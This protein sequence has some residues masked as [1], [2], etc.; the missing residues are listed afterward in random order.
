MENT[1]PIDF[2]TYVDNFY[3]SRNENIVYTDAKELSLTDITLYHVKEITFE[4]KS[5]RKEALENV[6]GSLRI[7]GINFIYLIVGTKTNV[8]FYFGVVRDFSASAPPIV[9]YDIGEYVLLPSLKGNFRGSTIDYVQNDEKRKILD[10]I[11]NMENISYLEGVPGINKDN[12]NFQGSDRLVDVMLGDE[13]ALVVIAKPLLNDDVQQIE[14]NLNEAYSKMVPFVKETIQD[15][16][17]TSKGVSVSK[18]EGTSNS[19]STNESISIQTST[20]KSVGD[21]KGTSKGTSSSTTNGTSKGTSSSVTNGTTKGTSSSVSQ[22]TSTNST[23]KSTTESGNSGSSTST[24]TSKNDGSSTSVQTSKNEGTSESKS[25]TKGETSGKSDTKGTAITNGDNSSITNGTN[26]GTSNSRSKTTEYIKKEV[27]DWI[28][29]LD[30]T[31]FTRLDYGKGKG[32]Y[33]TTSYLLANQVGSLLKLENTMKS[34]YAG[35]SGNKVPLSKVALSRDDK[36]TSALK[37][38]Q[39]PKYK[40]KNNIDANEINLRATMSQF[41]K[42]DY[43]FLGNWISTNELSLLAGLPQKEVVG[44]G[45]REEVEF[46]LNFE[47]YNNSSEKVEIGNVVQSGNVLNI[48]VSIDKDV[49]NKHI[50]VTGVTGSGKTTTCQR[51]L[52]DSDLPF[53]VIEPAKTEYRILRETYDDLLIFTLGN[54]NIAPFRLNPFEFL[55]HESITSRVDMVKASIESSFDMEAAIPQII[56]SAIY[57]CYEKYGWNIA[58]NTNKKY[59]NPFADGVYAFPTISDVLQMTETVV[60]EQGFDD[61]LKKDYI[62]SIK[63]RL[64]SLTLGSKGLMLDTKRSIN[65]RDL[66][67][68]R[69]VL[70]L[71]EVRS[72][73]EKALIIGFV[74]TNLMEAVKAEFLSNPTFKHIT[75]VEEAHRLLSKYTPG[76]SLNKKQS[77]ETFT[78]MLAE[79]RKYGECLIIADQ[80][81]GKLAPEVLK[82]TNTKIVHKIFAQ[83]DKEAIGNTMALSDEQKDFLSNLSVGRAVV[84]S[85]GYNKAIQIQVNK[86]TDTSSTKFVDEEDIREAVFEYYREHYKLGV[87]H[88]LEI[89]SEKPTMEEFQKYIELSK[90]S[91]LKKEFELAIKSNCKNETF[92]DRISYYINKDSLDALTKYLI[93]K[94]YANY[95]N[96][97]YEKFKSVNETLKEFLDYSVNK[98]K[99]IMYNKTTIKLKNWRN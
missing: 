76:D 47:N 29:Y 35:E 55:P 98:D 17:S 73:S 25:I 78:D 32:L 61:R 3:L 34:L 86:K 27:Q 43:G 50:F 72:S 11:N 46:G 68:K 87:Y 71:E 19:T 75:L 48:P 94:Y 88:G 40:L 96:L 41:I 28:K 54:D 92:A 53:L 22:G 42:E 8:S 12:E 62:G 16:E 91:D 74:L 38:F 70:E 93:S 36:R 4:G 81:P 20:S 59:E 31:I 2:L 30:E 37:N 6:I 51:I 99:E 45:L 24:Q 10:I 26:E 33:I 67:T 97:D 69:V 15:G 63:A 66:I 95:I 65:F 64:Q 23:T 52:V 60:E 77:V 89:L 21:T 80:I 57:A 44:L 1:R 9:T 18:T 14:S 85:Q 49:L 13:F 5:P 58:N 84:F 39:I 79:V 83:D 82:N 56:E 90:D 7:E